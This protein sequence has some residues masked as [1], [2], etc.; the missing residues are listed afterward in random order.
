M[1]AFG[2]MMTSN[3]R[4]V[5][6]PAAG[7]ALLGRIWRNLL[8]LHLLWVLLLKLITP[9]H[10]GTGAFRSPRRPG[11]LHFG[12]KSGVPIERPRTIRLT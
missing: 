2:E 10:L 1:N 3:A 8:G 4:L 12:S 6:V 11:T 5:A 9:G 7:V